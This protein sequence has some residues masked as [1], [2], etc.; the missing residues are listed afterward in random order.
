MQDTTPRPL[1]AEAPL[2]RD[3]VVRLRHLDL[4]GRPIYV[5]LNADGC[6]LDRMVAV[7]REHTEKVL[8]RLWDCVYSARESRQLKLVN[9]DW[10]SGPG[11]A[12]RPPLRPE[13]P[14]RRSVTTTR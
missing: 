8:R 13:P 1:D 12:G 9:D 4:L 7:D 3:C 2:Y 14:R 10:P 6:E 11:P 5:A